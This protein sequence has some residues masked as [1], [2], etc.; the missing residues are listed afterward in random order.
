[1]SA[2]TIPSSFP[3]TPARSKMPKPSAARSAWSMPPDHGAAVV[4]LILEDPELEQIWREEL[5]DMQ[6]RLLGLRRALASSHAAL[7]P[8]ATQEGMFA[9]LPLC[10]DAIH[11]L[12]SDHGIYMADD[13]RINI[14]GLR[15]ETMIPFASAVAPYLPTP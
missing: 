9:L 13:G 15:D 11:K 2:S 4:R 1:M 10:S 6:T 7:A 14:A 3:A 5:I 12:R 8:L